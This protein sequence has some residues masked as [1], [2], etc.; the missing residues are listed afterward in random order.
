[1]KISVIGTG[2]V[3]LVSATCL[4]FLGH[5]LTCV[6]IDS[7]KVSDINNGIAPIHED[8]LQDKLVSVVRN[9][10]LVATTDLRQSVLNSD[11]SLIAVGHLLMV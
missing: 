7:N 1:M 3:G 2:Y 8:N 10:K 9:N 4:A 11:V 5:D 6:D